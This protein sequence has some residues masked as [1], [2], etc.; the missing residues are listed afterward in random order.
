M[1]NEQIS[2]RAAKAGRAAVEKKAQALK[3][4][5][6]EY[7]EIDSIKP[8]SYNPNR[9][10]ERDFELLCRSIREDGFTQPI[11]VQ[12]QTRE[13][14]D[15]E[16]RWRAARHCGLKEI[17]VAFTDMTMEQMRIATLRHNR[18]RGSEDLEL[19]SQVLRD[20]REVGALEWAADSLMMT[21]DQLERLMNEVKAPD[22]LAGDD[23]STAWVPTK[24]AVVAAAS[25][26]P[27][28][29]AVTMTPAA[30]AIF[31]KKEVELAQAKTEADRV[32]IEFSMRQDT[33]RLALQFT[34][35]DAALVRQAFEPSPAAKLLEYC[36]AKL[37]AQAPPKE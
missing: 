13:I 30:K 25:A 15:G 3:T 31:E 27:N 36:K 32:K 11:V 2:N 16:H 8:N 35:E 17:P 21:D 10:S 24:S 6:I 33:Y 19:A 9:Q 4:L 22:D 23:F 14:V 34:G 26:D 1:S 20:L 37:A 5:Q 29:E 18:A 28:R 12:R 7:V